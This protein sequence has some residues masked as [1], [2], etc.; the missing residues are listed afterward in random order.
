MYLMRHVIRFNFDHGFADTDWIANAR[1]TAFPSGK[2][3]AGLVAMI[4]IA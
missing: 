3:T 4:Q 2:L 1:R